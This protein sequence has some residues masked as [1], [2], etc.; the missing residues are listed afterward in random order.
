[1]NLFNH[2]GKNYKADGVA[3]VV[4]K[5]EMTVEVRYSD[6]SPPVTLRNATSLQVLNEIDTAKA[7]ADS[8]SRE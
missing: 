5:D 8:A 6:G 3:A 2:K 4:Q 7:N 1:M